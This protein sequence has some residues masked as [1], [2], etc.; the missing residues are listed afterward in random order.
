VRNQFRGPSKSVHFV[1]LEY[2][3]AQKI[4]YEELIIFRPP[5][6][7]F[8][9]IELKL[10]L[11]E[12]KHADERQ[13]DILSFNITCWSDWHWNQLKKEWEDNDFG[14]LPSF[15]GAS[16]AGKRRDSQVAYE[17]SFWFDITDVFDRS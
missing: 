9:G 3:I 15:D 16:H 13:Y 4:I 17:R 7:Q 12:L 8:S 1:G 5:D 10:I 14:M 2:D 11:Q 6:Y